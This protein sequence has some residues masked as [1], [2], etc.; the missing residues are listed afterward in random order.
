MFYLLPGSLLGAGGF[1][2]K[3]EESSTPLYKHGLC[4]WPGCD[5]ACHDFKAFTKYATMLY[6]KN[7]L[8]LFKQKLITYKIMSKLDHWVNY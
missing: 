2:A 1:G 6:I 4:S 3:V 7:F 5:T 8:S